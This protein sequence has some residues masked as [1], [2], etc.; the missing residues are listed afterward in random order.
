MRIA[1]CTI[2]NFI[3]LQQN[4]DTLFNQYDKEES[5]VDEQGLSVGQGANMNMLID[6]EQLLEKSC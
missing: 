2:H 5:I 3:G 1:S 6:T 4:I